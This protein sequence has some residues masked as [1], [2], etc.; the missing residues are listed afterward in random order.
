MAE[1]NSQTF[2]NMTAVDP[3]AANSSDSQI[4]EAIT[5][6]NTLVESS[7]VGF[8]C[9][10]ATGAAISANAEAARIVGTSIE[11]LERQ[12][13]RDL[14]S[15]KISGLFE[16]A[17]LALSIGAK[18]RRDIHLKSTFGHETDLE[19]I[20]VPF[21]F[22]GETH[23]LLNTLDIT[24]RK[25]AEAELRE[26]KLVFEQFLEHSPIYVFFK[27]S[28]IRTLHLSKNYEAMLGRPINDLLGKNMHELFPSELTRTMV[29]DDLNV[30][31]SGKQLEV[32]EEFNG[33]TY[34][35]IKFPISEDGVPKYLAGYTTDITE[36]KRAEQ[37]IREA[38]EAAER[39]NQTKDL[40]L[41]TLSHEL[42]TP[43]TAILSWAQLLRS[44]RLDPS[45]VAVGLQTI[46]EAAQ[47]QNQI[48][49]DLLDI[50]RISVGKIA[51][52]IQDTEL[53]EVIAKA[54]ETV[55]TAADKKSIQLT[56][57]LGPMPVFVSADA[58]RLKQIVWNLLSNSIKF[59]PNRGTVDVTLSICEDSP[60][61]KAK[62][63]VRDSG[64]GISRQFLPHLF[65]QFSQAD[66]S[67]TRVHGGMGLGLALVKS[68]VN[69]HEGTI[70]AE[71]EGEGKGST[72]TILLPLSTLSNFLVE[73]SSPKE[74]ATEL[75]ISESQTH[76]NSLRGLRLL[77]VDDETSTLNS[78]RETLL[79]FGAQVT[80]A[81][82]CTEALAEFE[83]YTFDLVVSDIAMP[84]ADGYSLIKNIRKRSNEKGGSTPA[85]ALTAYAD[86]QTRGYALSAG[87]QAHIA[88][89]VDADVLVR[90]ILNV[91]DKNKVAKPATR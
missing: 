13:F 16:M 37:S 44:N 45:K 60:P 64:K 39:A 83:N 17:E 28:Q 78:I 55:R 63:R 1:S 74:Q 42:R 35:T 18:Q 34:S 14:A 87:F 70:E 82:S 26:R 2:L 73:S 68:L 31:K 80:C 58:G 5:Y 62:I 79:A 51:L 84:V 25:K 38:K 36:R 88:K 76:E 27:D 50:S 40:F 6:I 72:F 4:Q 19:A 49:S 59:T 66:S 54:I 81:K 10:K 22:K 21:F 89:P 29:Q 53:T 85:V 43:L 8:I 3:F 75:P 56:Q 86:A 33:H 23:L 47:A 32:E 41:A 24:D 69:L 52:D 9:Y 46:E 12:N 30:L 57:S 11:N 91:I 20:M 48:I 61:A 77:L 7:P 71:S 65:E 90:T 15:W 67:S